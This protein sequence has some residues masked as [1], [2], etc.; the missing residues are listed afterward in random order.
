VPNVGVPN[1]IKY[2]LVDL[3]TQVDPPSTVIVEDLNIPL[4]Q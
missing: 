1:F 4:A 2:I 3:K